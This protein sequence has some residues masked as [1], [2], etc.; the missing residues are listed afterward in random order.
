[1]LEW[2]DCSYACVF[3]CD[4]ERERERKKERQKERD[5]FA[6]FRHSACDAFINMCVCVLGG[7]EGG[8]V[9]GRQCSLGKRL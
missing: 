3:V 2:E 6:F 7:G 8:V 5:G 4:N 9:V 1:M